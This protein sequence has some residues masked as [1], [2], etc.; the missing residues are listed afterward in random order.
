MARLIYHEGPAEIGVWVE[1]QLVVHRRGA[2]SPAEIPEDVAAALVGR[3]HPVRWERWQPPAP[4][5][6]E[7]K[8]R[9][10]KG[11]E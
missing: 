9:K 4:P 10:G 8:P 2:P 5:K 6:T 7:R 1:G 11:G 3:P